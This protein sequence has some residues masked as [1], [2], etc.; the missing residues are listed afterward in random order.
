MQECESI[1]KKFL[2]DYKEMQIRPEHI[3]KSLNIY[4]DSYEDIQQY[5]INKEAWIIEC[6]CKKQTCNIYYRKELILENGKE[7]VMFRITGCII[8]GGTEDMQLTLER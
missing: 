2:N 6:K 7:S 3:L 5:D 4:F 8:I 1:V